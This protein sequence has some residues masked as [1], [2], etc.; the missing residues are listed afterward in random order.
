MNLNQLKLFYLAVKNKSVSQAARELNITQPAVTKGIRRIQEYYNV[1]LVHRMGKK[2]A[3][4]D[5]GNTLYKISEKIFELEKLAEDSLSEYQQETLKSLCIHTSESFGAYFLPSIINRFNRAHPD[6]HVTVDILPNRQVVENTI[7]FKNDMGFISSPVKNKKLIIRDVLED[8][9][10]IIVPPG[11]PFTGKIRLAPT[12]LE[13]ETMIMHE[14]GSILQDMIKTF[15]ADSGI[16]LSMPI[17]LSNNEAIKRAVEGKAGIA[18]MSK[19]VVAKE[20]QSKRLAALPISGPPMI[21]KFHLIH[22]RN[23]LLIKPVAALID[24]VDQWAAACRAPGL[25]SETG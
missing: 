14:E 6:I 21:R 12:D 5:A 11:H 3:L 22:H 17:T 8:E 25:S 18:M 10:V 2:L 19:R 1:P 20:V 4:T 16:S 13:G 15:M 23:K 9:L 24:I 7:N